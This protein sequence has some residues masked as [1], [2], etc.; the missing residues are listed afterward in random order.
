VFV[1]GAEAE[2]EEVGAVV[3]KVVEEVGAEVVAVGV[4]LDFLDI[5]IYKYI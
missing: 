4:V 1:V 5:S 2:V 3:E